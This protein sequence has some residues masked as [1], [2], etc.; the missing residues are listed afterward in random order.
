MLTFLVFDTPNEISGGKKRIE[1]R[2]MPRTTLRTRFFAQPIV[3]KYQY[4][5]VFIKELAAPMLKDVIVSCMIMK[6]QD[7]KQ[8]IAVA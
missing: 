4:P 5:R 6:S 3:N 2:T 8:E 7:L 1:N